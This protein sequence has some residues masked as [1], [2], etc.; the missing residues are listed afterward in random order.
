MVHPKPEAL[1]LELERLDADVL[2][3]QEVSN[4][5]EQAL[6]EHRFLASHPHHYL[7][8]REDSF[9]S[10]ILSRV[11]LLEVDE[12][13]LA[14]LP[15]TR[16]LLQLGDRRVSLLNVHTLPPRLAEYIPGHLEALDSL[17]RWAE[18]K[19]AESFI[20]AGDFNS[21]PYSRFSS[22]MRE[23]AADAW[24][25]AGTGY[26][27]TAPNGM[28]PLPPTRLDHIFLSRDLTPVSVSVGSG[29]GSDHRPLIADV[30][31]RTAGDD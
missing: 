9:G 8:T 7:V 21:T 4:L 1:L 5:W 24:E 6:E 27:H 20:I 11:E 29:Q 30:A 18:G 13:S 15:Q 2:L 23:H 28:F 3:L 16:A 10:A 31:V 26:G 22:R 17:V 25:L 14:G 19:R 12:Y